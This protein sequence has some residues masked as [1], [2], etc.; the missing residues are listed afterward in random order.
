MIFALLAR[1]TIGGNRPRFFRIAFCYPWNLWGTAKTR[2]MEPE[3][4]VMREHRDNRDIG[5][6]QCVRD[7]LQVF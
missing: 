1:G 7:S 6:I 5:G 4:T 2:M 3:M